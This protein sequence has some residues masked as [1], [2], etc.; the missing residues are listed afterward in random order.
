MKKGKRDK[1]GNRGSLSLFDLHSGS[2]PTRRI[3]V[4]AEIEVGRE[5][6]GGVRGGVGMR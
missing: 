4:R 2:S 5:I 6:K 1:R 3:G